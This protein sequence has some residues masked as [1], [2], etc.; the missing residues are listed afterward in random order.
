MTISEGSPKDP[1]PEGLTP[2]QE[3]LAN[4][5]FDTKQV[6]PVTRR[7]GEPGNY[8]FEKIERPTSPID[9]AQENE[10][11]LK[12]HEKKPDAPLSPVYINLR[13]LPENVLDQVGLVMSE[14]TMDTPA[15]FCAGIPKAGVPLAEAYARRTGIPSIDVFEKEETQEGRRIVSGN[16]QN[17]TG[18]SLRLIDDLATGGDTKLEAIKAAEGLGCSIA[19]VVV[20]VD[21]QQG[22]R[23]QLKEAGYDLKAAF[24]LEQLL[25]YGL[26]KGKITKGQYE[27]VTVY[28]GLH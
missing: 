5:L 13:N 10:F 18:A 19:D 21:R 16:Q 4:M 3:I 27:Q 8:R 1:H 11:A 15:D 6:A 22:A 2:N 23:K 14:L 28:L 20:L 26:R 17:L 7:V 12:L 9:F 24:T 25:R